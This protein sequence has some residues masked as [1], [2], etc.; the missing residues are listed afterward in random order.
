MFGLAIHTA[1]P[2]LGLMLQ[3]STAQSDPIQRHHVWDLGREVSSQLHA[4]MQTFIEP[5]SWQSVNFVAVAK[6]PG[7]FTGTRIGV[8]AART[9]AQQLEVPLF[10]VPTLAA[11][12]ATEF[13]KPPTDHIFAVSLPAKRGA[14]YGAI[15][16]SDEALILK[17]TMATAVFAQAEWAQKV[18]SLKLQDRPVLQMQLKVGEGFA[19]T[20]IG[21]M[22]LAQAGWHQGQRPLWPSVMPFYGQHPVQAKS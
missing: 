3:G 17:E 19:K 9:L 13:A 22:N 16:N 4:K 1:S 11:V 6:G 15:Y 7:G 21:V 5:Y 18:E 10:G 14:V 8:V 2:Q 12:V 20:V